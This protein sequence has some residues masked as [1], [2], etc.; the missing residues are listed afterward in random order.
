MIDTQ[1]GTVHVHYTYRAQNSPGPIHRRGIMKIDWNKGVSGTAVSFQDDFQVSGN[2]T[3]TEALVFT[4]ALNGAKVLVN[5]KNTTL[6][7]GNDAD[8]FNFELKHY[9]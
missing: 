7:E 6:A 4:A 1:T 3:L 2:D 5:C 8:E 9:A